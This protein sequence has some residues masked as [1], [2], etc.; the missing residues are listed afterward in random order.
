[1][2]ATVVIGGVAFPNGA[3]PESALVAAPGGIAGQF[4]E[5][6]T[7][8]QF[9]DLREACHRST[10]FWVSPG[11]NTGGV[12]ACY[13]DLANQLFAKAHEGQ[14]GIG[15][16][17]VPGTSN[18]GGAIAIDIAGFEHPQV[19]AWLVAHADEYGFSNTEGAKVHEPWHWVHTATTSTGPGRGP[20]PNAVTQG[21]ELMKCIRIGKSIYLLGPGFCH[22]ITAEEWPQLQACGYK[23]DHDFG[24][25]GPNTAAQ[26][27][28]DLVKAAHTRRSG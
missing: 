3:V 9:G 21:D 13:R 6:A 24:A 18:H 14:H 28:F 8:R 26:R 4:L 10:G 22:L 17:A 27:A 23:I 12:N 2:A 20:A 19:W 1:M 25:G 16:A 5:A 7:A 11:P 15:T